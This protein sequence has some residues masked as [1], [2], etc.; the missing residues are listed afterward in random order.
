MSSVRLPGSANKISGNKQKSFGIE[1]WQQF[2]KFISDFIDSQDK[3]CY[4]TCLN[5]CA[6][7]HF[8]QQLFKYLRIEKTNKANNKH[9]NETHEILEI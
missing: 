5:W 8:I 7:R 9:L 4:L 6:E 3:S 1:L 2:N